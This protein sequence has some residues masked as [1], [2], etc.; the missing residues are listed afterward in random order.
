MKGRPRVRKRFELFP[1]PHNFLKSISRDNLLANIFSRAKL[2]QNEEADFQFARDRLVHGLQV[3]QRTDAEYYRRILYTLHR[4]HT[5]AVKEKKISNFLKFARAKRVCPIFIFTEDLQKFVTDEETNIYRKRPD[6]FPE[7]S[8]QLWKQNYTET[9]SNTL[10]LLDL[11][12]E[13]EDILKTCSPAKP[14]IEE[15]NNTCKNPFDY[16]TLVRHNF[17]KL[18]GIVLLKLAQ[19]H[20]MLG[21]IQIAIERSK[22]AIDCFSDIDCHEFKMRAHYVFGW[23]VAKHMRI[24]SSF[25]TDDFYDTEYHFKTAFNLA[26]QFMLSQKTNDDHTVIMGFAILAADA[27]INL[28]QR[29]KHYDKVLEWCLAM[30]NLEN[31]GKAYE[32]HLLAAKM[33]MKTLSYLDAITHLKK[34]RMLCRSQQN[35]AREIVLLGFLSTAHLGLQDYGEARLCLEQAIKVCKKN[36]FSLERQRV[37]IE[38]TLRLALVHYM[39]G[40]FVEA[41]KI[42]EQCRALMTES[43][44]DG[45]EERDIL[46]SCVCFCII[47]YCQQSLGEYRK[48]I[49]ILKAVRGSS[50]SQIMTLDN[51]VSMANTALITES[52]AETK[53][54]SSSISLLHVTHTA[55][56]IDHFPLMPV[57]VEHM[58]KGTSAEII[59]IS[60]IAISYMY[61]RNYKKAIKWFKT[62]AKIAS[63]PSHADVLGITKGRALS[64]IGVCYLLQ[65]EHMRAEP[66]LRT[67]LHLAERNMDARLR[68]NCLCNLAAVHFFSRGLD[69]AADLW[70]QSMEIEVLKND[71]ALE[72]IAHNIKINSYYNF[73]KEIKMPDVNAKFQQQQPFSSHESN[74]E[75]SRISRSRTRSRQSRSRNRSRRGSRRARRKSLHD[76]EG[77]RSASRGASRGGII[78][79]D[80][81]SEALFASMVEET[82]SST[83]QSLRQ[84]LIKSTSD[85]A[86]LQ[87]LPSSMKYLVVLQSVE[88]FSRE[89]PKLSVRI[90][91]T[92]RA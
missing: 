89:L 51:D 88:I 33:Y 55:T 57:N 8:R 1:D 69:L 40:D 27:L 50:S 79:N 70:K 43:D 61:L 58:F 18:E 4:I 91:E 53:K 92:F 5:T 76:T 34:A 67:A 52:F 74:M 64:N 87:D 72:D 44:S 16:Y 59:A 12:K 35:Y 26:Q 39:S 83:I 7:I 30:I 73:D 28:Y 38:N 22:Q 54:N 29:D 90:D 48:S 65:E 13:L 20:E 56:T 11:A 2:A 21:E 36:S 66:Y 78:R 42:V 77:N 25:F 82:H 71:N 17:I 75:N 47:G 62:V 85:N 37:E 9:G 41:L 32:Y 68:Q 81:P 60:G 24:D 3:L 19:L 86:D 31:R 63:V 14:S 80:H 46:P 45:K 10:F 15:I 84:S 23:L 6:S 49:K